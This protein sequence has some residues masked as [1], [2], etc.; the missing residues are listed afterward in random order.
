MFPFGD[1]CKKEFKRSLYL[2]QV[3]NIH[4]PHHIHFL[5]KILS[6]T[7][8][9]HP[10]LCMNTALQLYDECIIIYA[11]GNRYSKRPER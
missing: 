10:Y 1:I 6:S 11:A 9:L 8:V 2:L 7:G 3:L 5:L 4:F